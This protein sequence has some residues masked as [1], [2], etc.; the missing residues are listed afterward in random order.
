[1][2]RPKEEGRACSSFFVRWEMIVYI[3]IPMFTQNQS[4]LRERVKLYSRWQSEIEE[5]ENQYRVDIKP[6]ALV[7]E[8]ILLLSND[9]TTLLVVIE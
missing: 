2:L 6:K 4:A 3:R 9:S 7:P 1:M 8:D 5:I